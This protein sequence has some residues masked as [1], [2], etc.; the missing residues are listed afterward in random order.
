M[1]QAAGPSVQQSQSLVSTVTLISNVQQRTETLLDDTFQIV[2]SQLEQSITQLK[3]TVNDETSARRKPIEKASDA[4]HAI[5][6][7]SRKVFKERV[8][9]TVQ[10]KTTKIISMAAYTI[11]LA[12]LNTLRKMA[13]VAN[14]AAEKANAAAVKAGTS[15]KVAKA[16]SKNDPTAKSLVERASIEALA[17]K[18]N[19]DIA[20]TEASAIQELIDSANQPNS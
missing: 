19:A 6:E 3:G 16:L 13:I 8:A 10:R 9:A 14:A 12:T 11:H 18:D 17:A 20:R 4:P 5:I 2:L 7:V 15:L 1:S